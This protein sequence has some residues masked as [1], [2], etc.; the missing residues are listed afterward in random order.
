MIEISERRPFR[1]EFV[2]ELLR[3]KGDSRFVG[4]G[5][6]AEAEQGDARK[7]ELPNHGLFL[8]FIWITMSLNNDSCWRGGLMARRFRDA[9]RR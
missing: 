1:E 5:D 2:A 6:E 4:D 3:F 9:P 8:K 7:G